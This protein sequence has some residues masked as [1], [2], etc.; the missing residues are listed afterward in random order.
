M[1]VDKM[2]HDYEHMVSDLLHWIQAKIQELS[3]HNFPN[4]LEGIQALMQTFKQY[5][6]VEKPPK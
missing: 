4:S 5:R 2:Q 1:D 6:T 3:D